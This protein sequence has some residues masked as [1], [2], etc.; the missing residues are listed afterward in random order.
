[1][2]TVP[3][4]SREFNR[5]LVYLTLALMLM[6][7]GLLLTFLMVV[8]SRSLPPQIVRIPTYEQHKETTRTETV[9]ESPSTRLD[10]SRVRQQDSGSEGDI[11]EN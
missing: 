10:N 8:Y 3:S 9:R 4:R 5:D 7:F 1:M 6:V 11:S 2:S